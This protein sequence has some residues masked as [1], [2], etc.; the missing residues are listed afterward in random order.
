MTGLDRIIENALAEDIHTGDITTLAVMRENR[1]ARARLIAKEPMVL[2]GI[3]AAA[4]VF[5]QLDSRIIFTPH[6]IDGNALDNGDKIAEITGDAAAL[7]RGNGW[8]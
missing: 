3:D 8:L 2:A 1:G 5:Q 4:R 6:F 7:C